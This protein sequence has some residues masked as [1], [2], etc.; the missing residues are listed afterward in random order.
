MDEC[1]EQFSN[2]KKI[3]TK[4]LQQY[5][6]S[7]YDALFNP[8]PYYDMLRRDMDECC[9]LA[10][11]YGLV[12]D[13]EKG[14]LKNGR[15]I[16]DDAIRNELRVARLF[17]RYFGKG[18]LNW[19][20]PGTGAS[21]GEFLLNIDNLDH[22]R[23]SIFVEV[24]TRE[25]QRI[26]KSGI[27]C[28]NVNSI[29]SSL[30][31]AYKK[32]KEGLNI[33]FLVVLCHDHFKINIDEYQVIKACFGTID[34]QKGRPEVTSHGYLSPASHINLSAIALYY[35]YV[36]PESNRFQEIFEVFHNPNAKIK[37]D[38]RIFENKADKQ[39]NLLK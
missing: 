24:K 32:V 15:K 25:I 10:L 3:F 20:P 17:E 13:M 12:V 27:L 7:L 2:I 22:T 1:G 11:R 14:T 31:K 4:E 39:F 21:V 30:S 16:Y 19:D 18:C 26:T 23:C 6:A 5:N 34:L 28:P 29:I 36:N 38:E 35:F 37:I 33:P 9:E 8:D